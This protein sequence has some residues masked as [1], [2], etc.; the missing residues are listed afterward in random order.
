[1]RTWTTENSTWH[2]LHHCIMVCSVWRFHNTWIFVQ[3]SSLRVCCI[4]SFGIYLL[5][6]KGPIFIS[7]LFWHDCSNQTEE[8]KL[9]FAT[10][11]LA[12]KWCI[13]CRKM[14]QALRL[15]CCF[16]MQKPM[17]C[18]T[19]TRKCQLLTDFLPLPGNTHAQA[20]KL[21]FYFF[22]HSF[23]FTIF[24]IMISSWA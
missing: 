18:G 13:N 21:P 23:I 19:T 1:M 6:A 24:G 7:L 22:I 17:G 16:Q 15:A 20:W 9:Y 3:Y 12:R 11:C 10:K 4:L 5:A 8:W 2:A 14:S